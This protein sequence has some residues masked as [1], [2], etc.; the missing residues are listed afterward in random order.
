MNSGFVKFDKGYLKDGRRNT[1]A[2]LVLHD[3]GRS[4]L[5]IR[6]Q[7]RRKNV[8]V[9]YRHPDAGSLR[10][11]GVANE[12]KQVFLNLLLDHL[13]DRFQREMHSEVKSISPEA[14]Q[15]IL[16]CDWPGNVRDLPPRIRGREAK[17][18][19]E[20]PDGESK[21]AD[22]VK[23]AV[24]RLEKRLIA[25]RLARYHNNRTA[26]AD[27]LGI[28]RKTLFT[29]MHELDLD[30]G[31]DQSITNYELRFEGMRVAI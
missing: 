7:A 1:S 19:T 4:L 9:E 21:L 3:F 20:V 12:L 25:S 15:L 5:L 16:G 31:A 8:Q 6:R 17:E 23:E 26:T 24:S 28:T 22:A 13:L 11:S 10:I 14:R 29:K 30:A 2:G 18:E 27:S